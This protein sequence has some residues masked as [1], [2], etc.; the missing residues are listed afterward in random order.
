MDF[1]LHIVIVDI[2]HQSLESYT[3][4]LS[5]GL[6]RNDDENTNRK[7]AFMIEWNSKGIQPGLFEVASRI[8]FAI[9]LIMILT[10]AR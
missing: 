3:T 8:E 4:G 2:A 5:S 7:R 1:F 9:D 10:L 6:N